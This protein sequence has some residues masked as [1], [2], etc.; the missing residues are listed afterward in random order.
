MPDF[1]VMPLEA[2]PFQAPQGWCQ[3]DGVARERTN[4][5]GGLPTLVGRVTPGT[6]GHEGCALAWVA[7]PIGESHTRRPRP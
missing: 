2:D 4:Q 3:K 5:P 1:T 6:P 7:N